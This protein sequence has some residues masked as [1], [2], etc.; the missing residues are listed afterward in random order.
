MKCPVCATEGAYVGLL[1]VDCHNPDCMHYKR[2]ASAGEL[3]EEV[4]PFSMSEPV[5]LPGQYTAVALNLSVG[6]LKKET[7]KTTVLI[8][9]MASGDPGV[10]D[11]K[12]EFFWWDSTSLIATKKPCT[13]SSGSTFHVSGVDADGTTKYKTH[14]KCH[15]DGVP[16]GGPWEIEARIS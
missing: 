8:T 16:V 6:I 5:S 12:V 7:K 15:L 2:S 14:W 1:D 9:F 3:L 13:L 4:A 10:P 11:K